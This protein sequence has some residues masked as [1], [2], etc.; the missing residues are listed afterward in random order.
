MPPAEVKIF[1]GWNWPFF[2]RH[3]WCFK[4]KQQSENL[5]SLFIQLVEMCVSDKK[6]CIR[7]DIYF[8]IQP[9]HLDWPHWNF[10]MIFAYSRPDRYI[11]RPRLASAKSTWN[12]PKRTLNPSA[13]SKLSSRDQAKYPRT[14]TPSSCIAIQMNTERWNSFVENYFKTAKF[15]RLEPSMTYNNISTLS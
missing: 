8:F 6:N 3:E 1:Y 13:H 11:V 9:L 7:S 2:K 4:C 5:V 12:N 14:L 15:K 10:E